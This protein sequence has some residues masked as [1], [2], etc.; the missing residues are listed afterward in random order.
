MRPSITPLEI[1]KRTFPRRFRGYDFVEV[2]QFLES[3][4]EDLEEFFRNYDELEREN[5]HLKEEVAR[6][7][8]RESTLRETLLLAQKSA[9]SLRVETEKEAERVLKDAERQSERLMQQAMER[10]A[11]I[12]KKIRELRVERRNFHL[13]LKG[14]IDMFQ[15]VLKFDREEDDLDASVSVLR[16]KRREGSESA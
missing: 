10:V 15:E 8:E 6:H 11:E 1:R 13:K 14:M 9:D 7:R 3:I 4:A 16:P 12:E 2:A 5:G